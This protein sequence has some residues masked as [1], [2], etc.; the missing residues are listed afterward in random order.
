MR[1]N[2][3]LYNFRNH[4]NTYKNV[5]SPSCIN[6]IIT[7]SPNSLQ[8]T[9]T[10]CTTLSDFHKHEMFLLKTFFRKTELTQNLA[11]SRSN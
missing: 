2:L 10:Y 8:S 4:E 9:S 1:K 7:D 3:S 6:L 11:I 5:N